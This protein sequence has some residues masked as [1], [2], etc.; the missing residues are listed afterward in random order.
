MAL[1]IATAVTTPDDV[2]VA[3]DVLLLLHAPVPPPNTTE[4]AVY[5]A[6]APTHNGLEPVTDATLAFGLTVKAWCA[7]TVLPQPPDTV[8]IILQL[9]APAAVTTPE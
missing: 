2:T 9:P 5:V 7:L 1:P 8:Y 4:P 3:I 6:L